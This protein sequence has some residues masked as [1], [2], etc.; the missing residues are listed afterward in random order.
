MEDFWK[1]IGLTAILVATLMVVISLALTG[2]NYIQC[3]QLPEWT[4]RATHFEFWSG[5]YIEADPGV[6]VPLQNWS[7]KSRS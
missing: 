7:Y 4:G 2:V 6:W 3:Q 1:V 5:C